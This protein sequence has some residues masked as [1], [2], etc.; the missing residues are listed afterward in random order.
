LVYT[1]K[2]IHQAAKNITIQTTN[3]KQSDNN[4]DQLSLKQQNQSDRV[5]LHMEG[6]RS[7]TSNVE[8]L[9][10][11]SEDISSEAADTS[12]QG[13]KAVIQAS[14]EIRNIA[15]TVKQAVENIK[16]L[17]HR[18]QEVSGITNT[19][20]AISE[21][22]NLLALNAAIEAARA[23]ESGRGFAVVADEVRSLASR[24]GEATAEIEAMLN[25]IQSE[26]S[27]TMEIMNSSLPQVERGL[28]LSDLSGDLLSDIEE[29]AHNSQ[30]NVKQVAQATAKQ[31]SL[32]DNLHSS[33]E[34]VIKTA[35]QMGETSKSLYDYNQM[36][37]SN[38][39]NLATELKQHVAYFTLDE[40]HD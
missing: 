1:I 17:T 15:K 33:M 7:E 4:L 30:E 10:S 31:M 25:E 5:I 9:V 14:M 2:G 39:E 6:V 21:Q 8:L 11:R 29:K 20:S 24:T 32:L 37:A 38:L 12:A 19:I 35:T 16:K 3:E 22:T 28:E 18:T 34:A 36:V 23:G 26:T 27:A 40:T 13:N